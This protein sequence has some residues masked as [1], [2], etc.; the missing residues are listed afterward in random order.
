[1]LSTKVHSINAIEN[2]V[3]LVFYTNVHCW[4]FRIITPGQTVFVEYRI[5]YTPEAAERA[6]RDWIY[7][8]SIY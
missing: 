5:Y 6:G 4:Q 2:N 1:M 7:L 8:K 3:L